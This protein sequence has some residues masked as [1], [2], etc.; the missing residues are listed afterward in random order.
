MIFKS[1]LSENFT[2]ATEDSISVARHKLILHVED[3]SVVRRLERLFFKGIVS[4]YMFKIYPICKS[5]FH[6]PSIIGKFEDRTNETFI[7]LQIKPHFY[8]YIILVSLLFSLFPPFYIVIESYVTWNSSL[9]WNPR[10]Y[11]AILV[12]PFI[13]CICGLN[14]GYYQLESKRAKEKLKQ[15]FLAST[16]NG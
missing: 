8:Q 5:E 4:E 10:L 15:I 2:I 12:L 14:M 16:I 6:A 1:L 7:H 13:A 3:S 9:S 11:L